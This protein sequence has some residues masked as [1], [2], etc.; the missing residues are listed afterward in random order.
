MSVDSLI[1]LSR[2]FRLKKLTLSH[3]LFTLT[4]QQRDAI[5]E[6]ESS[7]RKHATRIEA[8]AVLNIEVPESSIV[9]WTFKHVQT[10]GFR[11]ILPCGA[12]CVRKSYSPDVLW[13]PGSMWMSLLKLNERSFHN[14]KQSLPGEVEH[15][16]V[17]LPFST[18]PNNNSVETSGFIS[19]PCPTDQTGFATLQKCWDYEELTLH[20]ATQPQIV[21]RILCNCSRESRLKKIRLVNTVMSHSMRGSRGEAVFKWHNT[22]I[23]DI[24]N[25]HPHMVTLVLE[26]FVDLSFGLL[27]LVSK[28]KCE[29]KVLKL[30]NCRTFGLRG[31]E[32]R[33]DV[34]NVEMKFRLHI[35]DL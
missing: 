3:G 9:E 5:L 19:H 12:R 16:D 35:I 11:L 25:S 27:P 1:K 18:C 30:I 8:A 13:H 7:L 31:L 4:R 6:E 14:F 26:N 2:D 32:S 22:D 28:L 23:V 29:M 10:E 20:R 17:K 34:Q 24:I 21:K 15:L 33:T